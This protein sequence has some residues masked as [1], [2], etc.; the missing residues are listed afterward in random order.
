MS[1][2]VNLFVAWFLIMQIF[3]SKVLAEVGT[4]VLFVLG[5]PLHEEL[6]WVVG[7]LFLISIL[8]IV[9][10][11]LGE[12]PLGVGK[13]DGKGYKLGHGMLLVSSVF[14]FCVYV[15]PVFVAGIGSHGALMVLSSVKI[16]LVFVALGLFG[17]GL[18]FVYQSAQPKNN[19]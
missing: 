7:A 9:R 13:S 14:A 10:L 15:L 11:I 3:M 12:L 5:V 18:S 1:A 19:H 17:F 2:C 16:G 6:G 4:G 8:F